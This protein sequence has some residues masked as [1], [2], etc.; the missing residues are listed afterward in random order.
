MVVI[1]EQMKLRPIDEPSSRGLDKIS[2]GLFCNRLWWLDK[3]RFLTVN[4]WIVDR[5]HF[6]FH[7]ERGS[8]FVARRMDILIKPQE[9]VPKWAASGRFNSHRHEVN[10]LQFAPFIAVGMGPQKYLRE[11]GSL[12]S[13]AEI[14]LGPRQKFQKVHKGKIK[15]LEWWDGLKIKKEDLVAGN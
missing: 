13:N 7:E 3:L 15:V 4:A 6:A 10:R 8:N 9:N 12:G 2:V 14:K 11:E 1:N 5:I